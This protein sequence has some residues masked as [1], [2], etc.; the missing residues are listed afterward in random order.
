MT[1]ARGVLL[2]CSIWL[3][4]AWITG[5]QDP[6]L[7]NEPLLVVAA[8]EEGD[9]TLLRKLLRDHEDVDQR[10]QCR[11]SPLMKAALNG[12]VESV[13]ALLN[14]GASVDLTDKGGYT[15]M[16]L[17]ASN[18][19]AD[20]VALLINAGASLDH[21]ELTNGWTALIWA[22]KLGH[23]ESVKV[24]LAHG[25]RSGITDHDGRSALDWARRIDQQEIIN[26][27]EQALSNS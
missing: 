8:A 14:A 22:A 5:R 26:R 20:I 9:L 16:M 1:F 27:L 19:H 6:A 17:A 7:S 3:L 11:W 24:L 23:L 25:A 13:M 10:D 12:H 18:N 21:Q 2:V 15:A 4:A